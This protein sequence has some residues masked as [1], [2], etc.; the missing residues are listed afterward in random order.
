METADDTVPEAICLN[1]CPIVNLVAGDVFGVASHV[2]TGVSVGAVG[3]DGGHEFVVFIGDGQ[4]GSFVRKAVY[5][6]INILA[7][8]TVCCLAVDFELLFYLVK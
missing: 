1:P 2:E 4:F 8:N 6:M 3:T 5:D 7:G